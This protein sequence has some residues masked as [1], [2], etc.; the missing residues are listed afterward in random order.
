MMSSSR[1]RMYLISNSLEI[2]KNRNNR[3]QQASNEL[4]CSY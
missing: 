4:N 2:K 1:E 3:T